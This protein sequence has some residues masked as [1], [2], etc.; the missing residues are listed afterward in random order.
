MVCCFSC[1]SRTLYTLYGAVTTVDVHEECGFH[2][3][4]F[5]ETRCLSKAVLCVDFSR[6]EYYRKSKKNVG[7]ND[8]VPFTQEM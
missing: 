7:D 6:T 5:D 1:F 2:C 8:E 3:A 4:V